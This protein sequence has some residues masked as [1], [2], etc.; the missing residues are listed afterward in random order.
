MNWKKSGILAFALS[1]LLSGLTVGSAMAAGLPLTIEVIRPAR[2]NAESIEIAED[3]PSVLIYHTHTWEAYEMTET[4]MYQPTETWRTKDDTCNMI[5]VGEELA[6]ELTA[7]G[8][9][10]THDTTAFEPPLLSSAY[11]RSLDMLMER[12]EAGE[13][14]DY[15]FD[16][17]RDA[18]SGL[19]NGAN[20]V[21]KD[22]EQ[23]AYVMLLVGKGTGSTGSGFDER[24]DWPKNLE[25]AEKITRRMNEDTPGIAREVKIKSGRFNQHISTGALLI[26]IGNNK[27]TLDE[28]LASCSVIARAIAAAHREK[29]AEA[30]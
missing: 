19:V 11:T 22:G 2:E 1:A 24:P 14:Y 6:R 9:R 15:Y 17:H 8:F 29:Q 26:E 7:Q 5:R 3:A 12:R 25:L 21:E 30:P 20:G 18:Y 16:V 13:R 4:T 10:V 27:N 23:A 28:A